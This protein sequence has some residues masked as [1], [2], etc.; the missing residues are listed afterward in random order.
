MFF[1]YYCESE[2]KNNKKQN[3]YKLR[4]KRQQNLK[5]INNK[6]YI[7]IITKIIINII[8]N[9]ILSLSRS[10]VW[11]STKSRVQVLSNRFDTKKNFQSSIVYRTSI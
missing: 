2:K 7:N 8:Q 3:K 11:K 4:V 10:D 6:N 5:S 1:A 9:D